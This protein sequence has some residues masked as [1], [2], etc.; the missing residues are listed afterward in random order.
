MKYRIRIRAQYLPGVSNVEADERSRRKLQRESWKLNPR[1]FRAIEAIYGARTVDLMADRVNRQCKAFYSWTPEPEAMG[2]DCFEHRWPR[3]GAYVNPPYSQ[4]PR[5]VQKIK[6]ESTQELVLLSPLW[7]SQSWYADLLRLSI[8]EP[9]ILMPSRDLLQTVYAGSCKQIRHPHWPVVVWQL[10]ANPWKTR[11]IMKQS[12]RSLRTM[13][14][15]ALR[16]QRILAGERTPIGVRK[17]ELIHG[18]ILHLQH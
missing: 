13:H 15:R 10:S 16:R 12:Y 17:T 1:V 7:P 8:A 14:V 2:T 9:S 4:I 18:N 11:G 6:S 3:S 5:I